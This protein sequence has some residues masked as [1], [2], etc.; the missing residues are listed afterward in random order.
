[1]VIVDN[2]H[3]KAQETI[4]VVLN[5]IQGKDK[6]ILKSLFAKTALAQIQLFD[7]SVEKLFNYYDGFLE[8]Y[9]DGAGPFVETTKDEGQIFQIME[10]NF[11]VKTDQCEY[12]F[13]MQYITKGNSDD[14]G[15]I[16]LYVIKTKDDANLDYVYWGD[17]KFT[18]GIHVAI[19][20]D[21]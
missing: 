7:D 4:E 20:N 2:D 17:G 15:I 6:D 8:S 21:I 1:M 12:R 18:P 11:S 13:A 9:D 10:S 16:S 5:A 19:S 3:S 14:I